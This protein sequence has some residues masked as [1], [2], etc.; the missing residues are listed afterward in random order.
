MD[1][2]VS[3]FCRTCLLSV[4]SHAHATPAS[5]EPDTGAREQRRNAERLQC[6]PACKQWP[7]PADGY[8]TNRCVDSLRLWISNSA[9][10]K[11]KSGPRL[12]VFQGLGSG[13]PHPGGASNASHSECGEHDPFSVSCKRTTA[14][15]TRPVCGC[16]VV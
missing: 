16:L 12:P 14:G 7:H 11:H 9:P 6:G 2:Y 4:E 3:E 10:E 8:C 13:T 1:I 15:E 5:R